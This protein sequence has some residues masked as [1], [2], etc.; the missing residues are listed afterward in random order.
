[1]KKV[2]YSVVSVLLIF[3]MCFCLAACGGWSDKEISKAKSAAENFVDRAEA[4]GY[5]G[6]SAVA[7]FHEIDKDHG[8][9]AVA[10]KKGSGIQTYKL[11]VEKSGDEYKVTDIEK[12]D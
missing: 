1:M 8:Y 7:A 9:F 12:A 3:S 10:E 2:F 4:A 11:Y 5:L 6:T